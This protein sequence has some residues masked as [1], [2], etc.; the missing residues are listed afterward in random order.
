MGG[1]P[2]NHAFV[3]LKFLSQFWSDT[4]P[5]SPFTIMITYLSWLSSGSLAAAMNDRK[6]HISQNVWCMCCLLCTVCIYCCTPSIELCLLLQGRFALSMLNIAL[7]VLSG[8]VVSWDYTLLWTGKLK[9]CFEEISSLCCG[10]CVHF[11]G[12]DSQCS[13]CVL[14]WFK[15]LC[16][17]CV[18]RLL[19]DIA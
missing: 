3:V 8:D 11:C 18:S 14:C 17:A 13:V 4:R 16:F 9:P 2:C 19:S 7:T 1:A 6:V 12:Q 15:D 10:T 5:L